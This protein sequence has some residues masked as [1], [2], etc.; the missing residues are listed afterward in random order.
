MKSLHLSVI[1]LVSSLACGNAVESE[2]I[3][4]DSKPLDWPDSIP[5][6]SPAKTLLV[7]DTPAATFLRGYL[8]TTALAPASSA[9]EIRAQATGI[10]D[11]LPAQEKV[12]LKIEWLKGDIPPTHFKRF[13]SPKEGLARS[14]CRLGAAGITRTALIAKGED[15]VFI[16]LLADQPGALSFRVTLGA[17]GEGE[18]KIEDRRQLVRPASADQSTSIGVHAWVI[19]FESDV[20]N[21]GRSITVTGEGEALI[22]LAYSTGNDATKTLAGTW[23]QLGNRY[24]PGHSPPDP[25]KIWQ[26]VLASRLKSVENSP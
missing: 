25:T 23:T 19:P 6:V 22:L 3:E 14:S 4:V 12:D 5:L 7:L 13:I 10:F 16:H 9:K 8:K 26:G 18:P 17:S 2:T 21:D 15:A 24:D 1:A 11:S 20:S